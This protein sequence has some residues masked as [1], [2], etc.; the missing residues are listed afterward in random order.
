MQAVQTQTDYRS[1]IAEV[2]RV[3]AHD[4]RAA[5]TE[6]H[7]KEWCGHRWRNL[8]MTAAMQ[9]LNALETASHDTLTRTS[10]NQK[11]R[12]CPSCVN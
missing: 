4:K 3:I 6:P 10:R 5:L 9:D 2:R 8:F 12:A 1:L 7:V 11:G